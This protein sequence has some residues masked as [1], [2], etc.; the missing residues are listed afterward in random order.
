YHQC[1]YENDAEGNNTEGKI[2]LRT[3]GWR[4]CAR[5]FSDI[6]DTAFNTENQVL[7]H[8]PKCKAG[9]DEHSAD[10][11][12]TDDVPVKVSGESSPRCE[13]VTVVHRK[14][15]VDFL[16]PDKKYKKLYE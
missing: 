2:L 14:I 8:F 6:G 11:D 12:R 15:I 4:T 10:S 13:I 16:R 9:T 5:G 1:E 3:L 7:P